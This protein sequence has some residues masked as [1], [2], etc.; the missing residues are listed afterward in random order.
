[1]KC[2]ELKAVSVIDAYQVYWDDNELV[3]RKSEVDGVIAG[4]NK[5]IAE[6]KEKLEGAK[7]ECNYWCNNLKVFAKE[8]K[9][10]IANMIDEHQAEITYFG[11]EI[12]LLK[13]Q[14]LKHKIKRAEMIERECFHKLCK[15]SLPK[16]ET[17][18]IKW[19]KRWIQIE[20]NLKEVMKCDELKAM[21]VSDAYEEYELNPTDESR[22]YVY[23]KVK[24]DKVLADNDREIEDLKNLHYVDMM[25]LDMENYK[26]KEQLR[27]YK[28]M[29]AYWIAIVCYRKFC[30][31]SSVKEEVFW[32]KWHNYWAD[33]ENK[34]KEKE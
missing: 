21:S 32:M 1:M 26:L 6:L 10:E 16:E 15:A 18:W 13:Q 28:R 8:K 9:A 29:R 11:M 19:L 34:L 2:D 20:T 23:Y 22:H 14:L 3:C 31:A 4:K 30:A 17:F 33:I 12:C 7:N 27:K 5:A 24:V 25:D